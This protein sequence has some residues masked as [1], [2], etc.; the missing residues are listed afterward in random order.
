MKS[1][2]YHII[3]PGMASQLAGDNYQGLLTNG[4]RLGRTI[5][6]FTMAQLRPLLALHT[7]SIR[8]YH[9]RDQGGAHEIDL[10]LESATG[11]IAG[12]EIKAANHVNQSDAKHL[13]WLR[14]TLG[15][16]FTKGLVLHTGAM[17]YPLGPRLWA[18]PIA[19]LWR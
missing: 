6:T 7:P 11:Q 4:D 5:D 9:L 12:I 17:T 10:V 8:A 18:S 1:P 13:A 15:P 19:S 16:T 2:K 3:D 14:D